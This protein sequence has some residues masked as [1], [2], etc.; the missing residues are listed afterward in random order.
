MAVLDISSIS[1]VKGHQR[2]ATRLSVGTHS[3][4]NI[5]CARNYI[6]HFC[7]DDKMMYPW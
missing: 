2:C 4:L 7:A 3:S 1:L 6:Q 5:Q